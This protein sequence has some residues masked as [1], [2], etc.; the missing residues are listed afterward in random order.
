MGK[1]V[2]LKDIASRVG[3]STALVS[4]VLNGQEKEKRVGI[5]MA[6]RI[7]EA[8]R[9][10]NYNPNHIARSLRK[11]STKTIGLIV[12]DIANPFFGNL[13]RVVEDEAGRHGYT[14]IFGSSDEDPDKSASLIESLVNRQ[15]DGFIIAPVENSEDQIKE[16]VQRGI[17]VV[18]VDRYL[19]SV[20]TNYVVL[21]NYTASFDAV[22][23]LLNKA[24]KRIGMI[25]YK[26]SMVHM[27]ERF[28]GY[29]DALLSSMPEQEVH[30][31]EIRYTHVSADIDRV[32]DEFV[33][34]PDKMDAIV[35]ATNALTVTG[36]YY[37]SKNKIKI[38]ENL[39]I[40]GFD[41]NAA[42]DF[43]YSP[44]T[45]IEQPIDEMGKQAVK[46]LLDQMN[47]SDQPV[48]VRLQHK[49]VKRVSSG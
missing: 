34:G 22:S 38:P 1:Q 29:Q 4:Y 10:L 18:L 17:P 46:L 27:Q 6:E 36:L 41:G 45:Y 30:L 28:S 19:D 37:L 12:A 21:D 35:F 16:L 8:A 48:Q 25:G 5:Q 44:L 32:L 23:H 26:T 49:L 15:V 39:A 31:G 11:G 33:K 7:R 43:F 13:A 42:F 40:I 14:V 9:E 47:G 24:Y 20:V 3:V 2:S